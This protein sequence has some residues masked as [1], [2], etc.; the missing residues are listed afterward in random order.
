MTF[1]KS[2][3]NGN[4]WKFVKKIESDLRSRKREKEMF[5][6][7]CIERNYYAPCGLYPASHT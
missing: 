7:R 6:I 1:Q 5:E 4:G 2:I 3:I